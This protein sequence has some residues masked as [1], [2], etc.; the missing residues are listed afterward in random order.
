MAEYR[1]NIVQTLKHFFE[2]EKES[3]TSFQAITTEVQRNIQTCTKETRDSISNDVH[4]VGRIYS[5]KKKYQKIAAIKTDGY[6][7][8]IKKSSIFR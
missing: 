1:P 8:N 6:V 5:L 3:L 2:T 4:Q 7:K